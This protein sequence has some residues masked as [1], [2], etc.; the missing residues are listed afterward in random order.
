GQSPHRHIDLT[1]GRMVFGDRIGRESLPFYWSRLRASFCHIELRAH[2]VHANVTDCY[3]TVNAPGSNSSG[4]R[5]GPRENG[6]PVL[7]AADQLGPAVERRQRLGGGLRREADDNA[8][9]ALVA[10]VPQP[11]G[12]LGG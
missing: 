8:G 6:G 4:S 2:S 12:A 1:F 7:D 11:A 5:S 9:H 10:I 3:G